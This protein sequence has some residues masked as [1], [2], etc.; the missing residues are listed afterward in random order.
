MGTL[1]DGFQ[2]R[3]GTGFGPIVA[4]R[5]AAAAIIVISVQH[6]LTA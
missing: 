5:R 1:S 6:R 2:T 3:L 4:V